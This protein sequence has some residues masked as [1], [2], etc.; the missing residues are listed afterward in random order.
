MTRRRRTRAPRRR[1]SACGP[2]AS[3]TTSTTS[4]ARTGISRSSRCSATSVS[5]T[6][7]RPRRSPGRGSSCTEVLELDPE[8]AVGDRPRRPTTRPT[9]IW[10]D[11]IGLPGRTDPTP[12][13]GQLL[14]MGDTGPCGPSSEIFWDLGAGYGPDGGPATGGEDRYIEIWNLVF[15]QYDQRADGIAS[16]CRKPSIDTGAGLER[17]LD[18]RSRATTSIWDI[19]V[20]RPLVA[21]RRAG[22][23]R[24]LRRTDPS[25]RVACAS[26]PTTPGPWPSS[27]AD[28]VVPSN[29]ERGY[30]L[31]RIIRRAVRHAYL[32]GVQ[33]PRHP[34]M[35]DAAVDVMG[36]AYPELV[37][38]RDARRPHV[39]GARRSGSAR[40]CSA[41][42]TSSTT[43]SARAT[44][45]GDDAFFLH[46][47]LGFPIDLTREIA[48]ERG[49]RR[50]RRRLRAAH[51]RAARS[52]PAP[53]RTKAGAAT[54]D[55]ALYRSCSRRT[56]RP[57]SPVAREQ[58]TE[59]DVSSRSSSTAHESTARPKA[60]RRG[61]PRPHALLRRVRRPGRR[62]RHA[63]TAAHRARLA[64][65]TPRYA[66]AGPHRARR[67]VVAAAT[68]TTATRSSPRID[69]APARP[70]PAQPHRHPPA[71]L[72]VA[73]G[74][75]RPRASR[76]GRSVAPDRLRFDFSHHDARHRP[77][78][79]RRSRR[80][81]NERGDRRRARPPLRDHEGRSRALGAIAFFGEKYGDIVRVLEAGTVDRAVRRHPRPRARLHRPDQDRQRELDRIEPAPHRGRD[82]RRCARLHPR[83][84]ARAP[85]AAQAL[86]V[87][88]DELPDRVERLRDEVKALQGELAAQRAKDAVADAARLAAT[89]VDG[90]VVA[91][92][93]GLPTD[94]LRRLALATR[95]ELGGA[96]SSGC[97]APTGDG[98]SASVVVAGAHPPASRRACRASDLAAPAAQRLGGGTSKR[99]RH[100]A[101]R[102]PRTPTCDDAEA[103]LRR[104]PGCAPLTRPSRHVLGGRLGHPPSR[105][106]G[107]R[108]DGHAG[109][110]ARDRG[111]R[112]TPTPTAGPSSRPP[113][114]STPPGSSS[115]C[116]GPCPD[117]RAR[118]RARREPR[119]P[120]WPPSPALT[121]PLRSTTSG[122]RP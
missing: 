48:G 9:E 67:R 68:I 111:A 118:R 99:R 91:R 60:R 79:S 23:R 103:A 71:A 73:R 88:P 121:C 52:G 5:V 20:F 41:A 119:R 122:S 63:S 75:R 50:R 56:A 96:G 70:D 49:R 11:E 97:S 21:A 102:R 6:T 34:D 46:D 40:R 55:T 89:A 32:L 74:A 81:A 30:V 112:A 106:G 80:L 4:A 84:G 109:V 43:S 117:G 26:S 44:S 110:P 38:Q 15:M 108:P 93:D 18:G 90:L 51:G 35:V 24:A 59:A 42:S 120:R 47:T 105:P 36:D 86:R 39:V 8:P 27:S 113:G 31:R 92:R 114:R 95:D 104:G 57:S 25:R 77:R 28:G 17:I 94:E 69:V 1:R 45:A 101:G 37:T 107:L 13:R 33:R 100:G 78:S 64:S 83:R 72:G 29:E 65:S 10:R 7:S 115:A 53:R 16:R 22:H 61:G 12:R 14:E 82:R 54:G 66:V 58:V 85:A 2:A 98:S 3:T 19:D 76:Q 87:K 116:P 62:H